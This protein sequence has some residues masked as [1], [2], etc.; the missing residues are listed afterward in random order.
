M[1]TYCTVQDNIANFEGNKF[2]ESTFE[3]KLL[4]IL[5][6]SYYDS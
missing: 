1:Y 2:Y 3:G 5:L 6:R 4:L